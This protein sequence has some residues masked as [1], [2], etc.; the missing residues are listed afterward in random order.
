MRVGLVIYGGLE[1]VSGGYLY[2]RM[3]VEHLRRA[4][5]QVEVYSLPWRN[6]LRH[7]GDNLSSAL[8]QRLHRAELDVLLQDELNHPSLAWLNRRLRRY[9]SYPIVCIVHH[10]RSSEVHSSG[11]RRFYRWVERRYLAS[12]DGF[13]FNTQTT[14]DVVE[15]LIGKGRPSV[16]AKPA[17]DHLPP[18]VT[19]EQIVARARR[20][21]RLH[22]L[23]VANLIRRKGLHTLLDSLRAAPFPWSLTVVGSTDVDASY[24]RSLLRQVARGEMGTRVRFLGAR[25]NAELS[26]LMAE[27]HLMV[28]PS[29][30]EGF[31]IVYL[32]G[33][34]FGLPAI[35]T[36]AG[37][38]QEIV[39]HGENGFLIAPGDSQ[40]LASHLSR[41]ASDRGLLLK[42]S[43]AARETYE[44]S[45]TWE[46]AARRIRAFL[47]ENLQA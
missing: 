12:V 14:R 5:D 37:G 34:G 46:N 10:L 24:T 27:S 8:F 42:L 19:K 45:P 2:D 35:G 41:L 25:P 36:T 29:S 26:G 30:Y 21:G 43:L 18:T 4:G 40:A 6:Y 32:E 31:G 9:T 28:V 47:T 17:A 20:P 1:R 11:L 38:A 3:L 33:M 44:R 16:V 39:R 13:I 15:N 23:F 7:L 22:I